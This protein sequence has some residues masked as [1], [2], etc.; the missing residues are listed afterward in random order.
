MNDAVGTLVL[1]GDARIRAPI[2]VAGA[3]PW[4]DQ[5]GARYTVS[6]GGPRCN[7][8]LA[9][10]RIPQRLSQ[11]RGKLENRAD[12]GRDN[13]RTVAGGIDSMGQE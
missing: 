3:Q 1:H 12:A 10:H 13:M 5:Y 2:S 4:V 11:G 7:L 6:A 9:G 8:E